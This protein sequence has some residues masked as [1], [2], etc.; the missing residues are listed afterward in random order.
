[1]KDVDEVPMLIKKYAKDPTLGKKSILES[2]RKGW[3]KNKIS[4][5][6]TIE[7]LLKKPGN[8]AGSHEDTSKGPFNQEIYNKYKKYFPEKKYSGKIKKI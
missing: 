2:I 3:G 6:G 1:M 4:S 7:A 5:I 8:I